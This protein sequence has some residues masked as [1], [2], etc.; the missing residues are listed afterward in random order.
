MTRKH[1]WL[2]FWMS[3]VSFLV[4]VFSA[5]LQSAQTITYYHNDALGSP[6]AATDST[7]QLVW[8]ENY[9]PYGS[10]LWRQPSDNKVWFTGKTYYEDIG[11]SY[12]GARWYSPGT[13]RF[14]SPDP[15]DGI[16]DLPEHR[17]SRYAYANNNPYRYVDPDGNSPISV[18]AKQV[19]KQGIR[20]GLK[21]MGN[22]QMRRLG[23][24]MNQSQRKEFM[25]DV[26]D[27]MSSLDSSPLEIALE[28]IPVAGDIYGGA[29]FTKQVTDAYGKMQDLE[30]KWVDR[31]YNSLPANQRKKFVTAMRNAGVRDAKKDAGLPRTGSGLEGHHVDPVAKNK[32]RMSDPRNI[33]LLTPK[34]HRALH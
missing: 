2:K 24:Y 17:F 1:K 14:I 19:A 27:V 10:K 8:R 32:S 29:K 11:L 4:L 28:L 7:G 12:F 3:L 21:K 22:R 25:I 18:F 30:N 31:I 33:R 9:R 20:Q 13:G 5:S 23:R 16:T 34:Q 26:V 15:V 6:V